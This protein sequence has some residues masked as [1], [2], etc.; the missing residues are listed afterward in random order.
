MECGLWIMNYRICNSQ[1]GL[2]NIEYGI[3]NMNH[4]IWNLEYCI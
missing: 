1:N 3:R 4:G 2:K